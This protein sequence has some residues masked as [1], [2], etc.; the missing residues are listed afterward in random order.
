MHSL[1]E[2]LTYL[3]PPYTFS[4]LSFDE[5]P[6]LAKH[7]LGDVLAIAPPHASSPEQIESEMSRLCGEL[8]RMLEGNTM[9][10]VQARRNA[11]L[12]SIDDV[13][14][15]PVDIKVGNARRVLEVLG[16]LLP[17]RERLMDEFVGRFDA[18]VWLELSR[19]GGK[20]LSVENQR[21]YRDEHPLFRDTL[22]RTKDILVNLDR[23]VALLDEVRRGPSSAPPVQATFWQG[24]PKATRTN[25]QAM[26]Y[27]RSNTTKSR[28]NSEASVANW[29]ER[30]NLGVSTAGVSDSDSASDL[31]SSS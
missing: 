12:A 9:A 8:C 2:S 19:L 22:Q 17:E 7:F 11:D 20:R 26:R 30:R 15:S 1:M 4:D 18:L 16:V 10:L 31:G 25:G 27:G 21:Q 3:P 13:P 5:L 24:P 23:E 29:R 14:S 28:R 6:H